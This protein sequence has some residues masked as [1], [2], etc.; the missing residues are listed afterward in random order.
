MRAFFKGNGTNVVKI[1]PETAIKLTL[2]DALKHV[3]GS[4]S[5]GHSCPVSYTCCMYAVSDAA[6]YS[7]LARPWPASIGRQ[8]GPT[9]P[10]AAAAHAAGG[11]RH[12]AYSPA[13]AADPALE[14]KQAAGPSLR[15][16]RRLAR[17]PAA[18]ARPQ[19]RMRWSHPPTL[20]PTPLP[21][22]LSLPVLQVVTPDPDEITPAQRMTAG[23]LAGAC[24]QATI[25]PFELVR[26]AGA[27]AGA[28]PF[29]ALG[30]PCLWTG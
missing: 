12:A 14:R 7:G 20:L 27:S 28:R 2:N 13:L 19:L 30:R 3:R 21:T 25:Y 18:P 24:A 1:A 10:D 8:G 26:W 6:Q 16:L 17:A 4:R 29:G 22:P 5:A 23:A 9:Q 11:F 15:R